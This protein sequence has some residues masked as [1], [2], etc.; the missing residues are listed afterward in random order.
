MPVH[1]SKREKTKSFTSTLKTFVAMYHESKAFSLPQ[2][3]I[4]YSTYSIRTNRAIQEQEPTKFSGTQ[5]VK[6]HKRCIKTPEGSWCYGFMFST[7]RSPLLHS[8]KITL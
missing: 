5:G 4:D 3:I 6:D 1:Q 2:L 7:P 8:L